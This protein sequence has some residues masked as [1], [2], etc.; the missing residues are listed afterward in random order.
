MVYDILALVAF[1]GGWFLLMKYVFPA[2]GIPT[3]MSGACRLRK[4]QPEEK[5]HHDQ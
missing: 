2:L 5:V 3:C 1:L 4:N